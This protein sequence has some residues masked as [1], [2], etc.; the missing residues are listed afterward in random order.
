MPADL[1]PP[2]SR[3]TVTTGLVLNLLGLAAS[4]YLTY[5]HFVAPTALACPETGAINCTKVTT[6]SESMVGPMPVALLGAVFFAAM[7]ALCSPHGWQRRRLDGVRLAAA[8]TGVAV[9]L[10]LIWVELFRLDAICLWCTFVHV[11]AVAVLGTVLWG[12]TGRTSP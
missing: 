12:V 8:G 2:I 7:V 10:Y 11:L 4:L 3:R 6:S 9:A 1:A 5:E